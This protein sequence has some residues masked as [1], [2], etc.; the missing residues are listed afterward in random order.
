MK[1]L[2]LIVPLILVIVFLNG[3]YSPM[4]IKVKTG[5]SNTEISKI[6][7]ATNRTDKADNI[8]TELAEDFMLMHPDIKVEIEGLTDIDQILTERMAAAEL[9]DITPVFGHLRQQ[10]YPLYLEPIDSLGFKQENI[11]FYENGFGPDGKLYTVNS[12]VVYNCITY[13]RKAFRIAG[14]YQLPETMEEF[15][16]VCK[17]LKEKG[18]IPVGTAFKDGWPL[19]YYVHFAFPFSNTGDPNYRNSLKEREKLLVDDGGDIMTATWNDEY[20]MHA[21]GKIGMFFLGTWYP[22]QLIDLGAKKEDIGIFPFPESKAL[23]REGDWYYGISKHSKYIEAAKAFFKW[24]WE[25][26]RYSKAI[27]VTPPT[28]KDYENDPLIKQ[29]NSYNLPILS[30]EP[31]DPETQKIFDESGIDLI[32]YFKKY[33]ISENPE[34]V[35]EE[36][37]KL[38]CEARK[39][40]Q[41]SQDSYLEN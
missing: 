31:V 25:D 41:V 30:K 27:G 35:V 5:E 34:E 12:A 11:F 4:A 18:I 10:D 33:L 38:W 40:I 9:P 8:L 23:F 26:G 15:Y 29:L 37:N 1:K 3:C 6:V 17:K 22:S 20:K 16:E 2:N 7:F 21:Q 39:K 32:K 13:N 24:L 19:D 14:V 36:V 28:K